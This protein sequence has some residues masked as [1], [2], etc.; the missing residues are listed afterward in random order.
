MFRLWT[1]KTQLIESTLNVDVIKTVKVL[2]VVPFLCAFTNIITLKSSFQDNRVVGYEYVNE[3]A[4]KEW[5]STYED[6]DILWNLEY[7]HEPYVKQYNAG[8][9]RKCR[10]R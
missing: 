8:N 9:M 10:P 4:R 5:W 7:W 3:K 1:V 2:Y 6:G